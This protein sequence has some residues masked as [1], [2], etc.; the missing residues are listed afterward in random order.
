MNPVKGGQN[1]FAA[2]PA[3]DVRP[4]QVSHLQQ[5]FELAPRSHLAEAVVSKVNE[6]LAKHETETGTSRLIPG[7]LLLELEG[8]RLSIPLLSPEWGQRLADGC[9]V[10]AARRHLEYEQLQACLAVDESLSLD[11]LWRWTDQK[12]LVGRRGGKEFLPAEPLDVE[13]LKA[14]PRPL[15]D[16]TLP[17]TLLDPITGYL[18][19]DYGCKPALARAMAERAAQIRQWCCPRISELNPGQLVWLVYSTRRVKRGQ[20]R[21]LAPVILTLLTAEEQG[22]QLASRGDLKLLKVRQIERITAEAWQQDGVLTMLDLEWLLN[23]NGAFL[24]QLLTAYQERFGVL[25]P[26]AGTVLDMGRTLTH[27]TIVVEMALEGLSTQQIARRIFH[28]PEAVDNY[29][30]LF[31]RVLVLRFFGMPPHLMRQVTGH[32]LALINEHLALAKKHFPSEKD[33]VDYLTNRGVELEK[34]Q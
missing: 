22:W 26:T 18:A 30:R 32:S 19:Q 1:R 20:G 6:A 24:R 13:S 2:L 3:R 14:S 7:E 9:K 12:E 28:T 5:R 4:V 17:D 33:L 10:A 16:V 23:V 34:A 25:L 8:E 21:L 29:L 11:Q 27:K 15:D 31:D